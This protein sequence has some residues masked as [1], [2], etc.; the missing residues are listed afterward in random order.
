MHS[1]ISLISN[2]DNYPDWAPVLFAGYLYAVC[3]WKQ[4]FP[5]IEERNEVYRSLATPAFSGTT[6]CADVFPSIF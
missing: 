6:L 4:L 5:N 2:G 3:S 1:V